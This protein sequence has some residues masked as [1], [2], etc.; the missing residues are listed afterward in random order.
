MTA[1]RVTIGIVLFCCALIVLGVALFSVRTAVVVAGVI[2]LILA[3]LLINVGDD[4]K[5]DQ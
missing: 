2:G 4:D 5:D 3:V 1:E